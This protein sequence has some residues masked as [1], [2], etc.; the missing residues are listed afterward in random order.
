MDSSSLSLDP[1][2]GLDSQKSKVIVTRDL[3]PDVLRG[4]RENPSVDVRHLH[5][6][7]EMTEGMTYG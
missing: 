3:G 2:N 1:N 7:L 6:L 4:L 5:S